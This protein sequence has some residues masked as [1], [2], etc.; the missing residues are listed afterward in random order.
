MSPPRK[1]ACWILHAR[2]WRDTSL[3]CELLTAG[4][5]RIGAVARGVRG[6]R[7]ERRALL[8]P[9][10]PLLAAWRGRG[11]LLT[12][13]DV[14]PAG[15]PL[16]LRGEALH[17]GFYLNELLCR[18]LPRQQPQPPALF[19]SYQEGL[20]LL[21]SGEVS[22]ALRRFEKHLLE[23]LGYAYRFDRV[24]DSGQAVQ[25][26]RRYRFQPGIGVL[27]CPDGEAGLRGA[28]FL[29]LAREDWR[30]EF[31]G[32]QRRILQEALSPL[33]GER[34]LRSQA[35][36]REMRRFR[37]ASAPAA[38]PAGSGPRLPENSG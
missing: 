25:P 19:R 20:L 27:A 22:M 13:T 18:L 14:E 9:F 5:G 32:E 3:L 23:F 24:A 16:V 12:L 21:R 37:R 29:A 34:P 11:E 26:E 28:C 6:G 4:Q 15:R 35:V 7:G 30:E 31:L 2:P 1:Q 38:S 36:Y 10:R 33:L 17:A 8:Q